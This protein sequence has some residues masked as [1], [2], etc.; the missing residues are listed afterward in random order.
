MGENTS[1]IVKT[2]WSY[3]TYE[4]VQYE[5][6]RHVSTFPFSLRRQSWLLYKRTQLFSLIAKWVKWLMTNY[7]VFLQSQLPTREEEYRQLFRLP[8]DEVS[9][10]ISIII[11][12]LCLINFMDMFNMFVQDEWWWQQ[13]LSCFMQPQLFILLLYISLHGCLI[14]FKFNSDSQLEA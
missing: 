5:A 1:L 7:Y 13:H 12:L 2:G 4:C 6:S 14:H 3:Y 10:P 8:S 9:S 11:I